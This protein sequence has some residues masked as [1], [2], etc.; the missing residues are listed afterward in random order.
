MLHILVYLSNEV[1]FT[2]V[3]SYCEEQ[4]KEDLFKKPWT[5]WVDFFVI[6]TLRGKAQGGGFRKVL[7]ELIKECTFFDKAFTL[8]AFSNASCRA[9]SAFH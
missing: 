6:L 8:K 3:C 4:M 2:S 7:P 5:L 1:V 9:S